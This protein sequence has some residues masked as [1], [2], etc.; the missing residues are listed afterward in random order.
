MKGIPASRVPDEVVDP[1]IEQVLSAPADKLL[2]IGEEFHLPVEVRAE[3]FATALCD[4]CGDMVV[5]S[6]LVADG[7][8][9]ACLACAEKAR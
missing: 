1:L 8:R 9:R 4:S 3:S 7:D 2:K 5:E 6:Y